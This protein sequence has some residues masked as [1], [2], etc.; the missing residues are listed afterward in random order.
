MLLKKGPLPGGVRFDRRTASFVGIP[1]KAGTYAVL[2]EAVDGL[3]VK[4]K[5]SIVITVAPGRAKP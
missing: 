5:G 3:K 1:T 2:V 4:A